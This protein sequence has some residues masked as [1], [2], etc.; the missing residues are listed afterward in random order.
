MKYFF[1]IVGSYVYL[2][3]KYSTPSKSEIFFVIVGSC[4][5]LHFN[6]STPSQSEIFLVIVAFFLYIGLSDAKNPLQ[7][8]YFFKDILLVV[9]SA[10]IYAL[11]FQGQNTLPKWNIFCYCM[12]LCIF[13]FE[14][15]RTLLKRNIFRYCRFLC[16]FAFQWKHTL[17]KWNIFCYCRFFCIFA[18]EVEHLLPKRNIVACSV[19]LHL[20]TST[21]SQSE[22]FFWYCSFFCILAFQI[23]N[24]LP[25]RNIFFQ[26]YSLASSLCW[27]VCIGLS[28]PVHP[29]KVKYFLLLYLLLYI[30]ISRP[31][32]PPK[33]KYFFQSYFITCSLCSYVC[34]GL[35]RPKHPHKVKYFF[36]SYSVENILP[37]WNIF[38]Y[39]SWPSE[40]EIFFSKVFCCL[41]SLLTMYV[42]AFQ[43]QNTLP[44]WNIFSRPVYLPKWNIFSKLFST[45]TPSQSEIVFQ[46]YSY[47]L[48]SCAHMYDWP[49]NTEYTF[50]QWNIIFLL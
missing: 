15:K 41:F 45:R 32:H 17:P 31:V 50:S 7:I 29:P 8:Q 1:V 46:S 43:N 33:V 9:P 5:Y 21:S 14:L 40:S 38:S 3:F 11:A 10:R 47:C 42:L 30:G 2:H 34:I 12:F 28:I 23:Q 6:G 48:F 35:S 36:Q 26:I 16:I 4:A 37:K 24:T 44:K 22:I 19:Y 20:K 25:K 27:Y 39:C 13:A 49:F 18:F